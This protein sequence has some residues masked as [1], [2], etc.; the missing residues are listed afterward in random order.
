MAAQQTL[1]RKI[2][3]GT[4]VRR[5]VGAQAQRLDDLL[6]V[7]IR[8]PEDGNILMFNP[9]TNTFENVPEVSGGTF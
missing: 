5:V 9:D 1:V 4:P 7:K 2:T 6:D 3:V 8:L